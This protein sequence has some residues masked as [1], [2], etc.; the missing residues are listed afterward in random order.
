MAYRGAIFNQK[1]CP[2]VH[3]IKGK[4]YSKD[5]GPIQ[6]M[7]KLEVMTDSQTI[8]PTDQPFNRPNDRRTWGLIGK[9]KGIS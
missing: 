3:W 2:M 5:Q 6:E 4:L 1:I 8:G 9:L 7:R